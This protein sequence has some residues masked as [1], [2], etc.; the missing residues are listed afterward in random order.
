MPRDAREVIVTDDLF[1]YLDDEGL[2]DLCAGLNKGAASMR[3]FIEE[4][5]QMGLKVQE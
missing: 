4:A 3:E 5:E 1:G 2:K